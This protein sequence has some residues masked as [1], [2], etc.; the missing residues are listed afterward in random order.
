MTRLLMLVLFGAVSKDVASE[1]LNTNKFPDG[2][3]FGSATSSYQIEGAWNTSG[4]GANI[5][6]TLTHNNP[7]YIADGS[8]GDV[9]CDSYTHAVDDVALIKDLGLDFYRFSLS[10][11]RILPTGFVHDINDDGI[12][13]Y[14]EI[15][16]ELAAQNISAMVT[17]YHFDLPQSLQD[18]G[19]WVNEA[20]VQFFEEYARIAF[21]NFGDRVKHWTTFNEPM[22]ICNYGYGGALLA[23]ALNVIGIAD[24]ICTHNLLKAHAAAYH[25]YND[26]F[27]WTQGGNIGI[28]IHEAWFEP[29][30]DSEE[31]VAAAERMM[32]FSVGWFANPIFGN[33]DYPEVMKEFV[34]YRSAL[35]G[36]PE[37]RLPEFAQAEVEYIKGTAD[38]MG[39]NHYTTRM[40]KDISEWPV[41][42][43]YTHYDR[44]VDVYSKEEWSG[45]STS[46]WLQ[47]VPW[48]L[49]KVL[50]W[51]KNQYNVTI[52]ITENGY[53]DDGNLNDID[54]VV[55]YQLYLSQVLDAIYEDEVDVRAYTFWSLLDNF[56]WMDG[57][58]SKFGL[59]QVDFSDPNRTRTPKL[60]VQEIQEIIA[61][62]QLPEVTYNETHSAGAV[63]VS[64]VL[65]LLV[66][67]ITFVTF[68]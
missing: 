25:V 60:S 40:A 7:E 23:P 63:R 44:R 26:E 48:G 64:S 66:T 33:G 45:S 22:Q 36:F 20:I 14:N 46:T 24:Y 57:Y 17:L 56:E 5:W 51:V 35:E 59:Y 39:L 54:R 16:D 52:Y 8:N 47:V 11:A 41:G 67:C 34:A 32:Q 42:T 28:T 29:K 6:D 65:L 61:N 18:M 30:S 15:L 58:E 43:P 1:S 38:Y 9:A 21:E 50:N 62:R 68:N 2:F 19:G 53:S 49:R 10:W 27:R 13:Y 31:D 12:R 37:S 4:K 55:Y 3:L